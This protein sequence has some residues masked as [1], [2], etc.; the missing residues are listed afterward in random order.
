MLIATHGSA[1]GVF[2]VIVYA[3]QSDFQI[4]GTGC[5]PAIL[6]VTFTLIT[7]RVGLG[8]TY[9]HNGAS[10]TTPSGTMQWAVAPLSNISVS[11]SPTS[12]PIVHISHNTASAISNVEG[13][14]D[15]GVA[16][17]E[18]NRPKQAN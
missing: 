2:F 10:G 15:E 11:T 14:L 7:V 6:G 12:A 8:W 3:T 18:L 1:W 17:H 9:E 13:G 16:A 5:A 4:I